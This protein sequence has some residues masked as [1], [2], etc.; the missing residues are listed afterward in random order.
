LRNDPTL[1]KWI[2]YT[3]LDCSDMGMTSV[4][5]KSNPA[6]TRTQFDIEAIGWKRYADML[7]RQLAAA[8]P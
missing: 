6:P 8:S 5:L 2:K 4:K 3:T 1:R 7:R